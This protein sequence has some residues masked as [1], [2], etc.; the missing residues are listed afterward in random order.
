VID[1]HELVARRK[2]K[3]GAG[4]QLAYLGFALLV[5]GM[6]SLQIVLDRGQEDD[7]FASV[8]ITRLSVIAAVSLPAFVAWQLRRRDPV[9]D[10]QLLAD[11]NFAVGNLMMFVLGFTLLATMTLLPLFVQ[12]L[13]GYTASDARSGNFG[14]RIRTDAGNAGGGCPQRQD[15][16]RGAYSPRLC[17]CGSGA[18]FDDPLLQGEIDYATIAWARVYQSV[19][20]AFL[21]IPI[22]TAALGSYADGK[23]QQCI[24][25]H[26][27]GAQSRRQRRH[28]TRGDADRP[29]RAVSSER[30]RRT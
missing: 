24:S 7:W 2:A 10:L 23:E 12:T 28:V 13:L 16:R 9:I 3:L 11:R 15:R 21:F 1:P 20:L 27:Y 29:T 22:N 8:H 18:L 14:W 30:A 19:P 26:Q 4:L 25:H 6:G 17:R 5:T